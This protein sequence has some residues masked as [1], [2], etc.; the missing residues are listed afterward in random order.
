MKPTCVQSVEYCRCLLI[1]SVCD[2]EIVFPQ[3]IGNVHLIISWQKVKFLNHNFATNVFHEFMVV[4]HSFHPQFLSLKDT[5][6]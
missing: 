2:I 4:R 1:K 6:H 3:V 5:F